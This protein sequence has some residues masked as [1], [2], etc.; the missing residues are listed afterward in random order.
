MIVPAFKTLDDIDGAFIISYET[1]LEINETIPGNNHRKVNELI[2]KISEHFFTT[3]RD[4]KNVNHYESYQAKL[5]DN[6]SDGQT[7][8]SRGKLITTHERYKHGDKLF[9]RATAVIK[10]V[11][12]CI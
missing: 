7:I 2:D 12:K 9:H 10:P 5:Y 3:F 8:T 6:S 1:E 11:F 4:A